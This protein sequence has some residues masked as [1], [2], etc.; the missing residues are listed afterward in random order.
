MN[1]KR[2]GAISFN[3]CKD[4]NFEPRSPSLFKYEGPISTFSDIQ[5]CEKFTTHR[6]SLKEVLRD[7][8]QQEGKQILEETVGCKQQA[9]ATKLVK[10]IL[11]TK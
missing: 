1:A 6:L 9:W 2:N 8:L 4:N 5:R 3:Y 11:W 10:L 7:T